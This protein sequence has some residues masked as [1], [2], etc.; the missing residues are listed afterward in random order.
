MCVR[1]RDKENASKE[2]TIVAM[3]MTGGLVV[4]VCEML[5]ETLF[6]YLIYFCSVSCHSDFVCQ[7]THVIVILY[8]K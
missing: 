4:V 2:V 5:T 6:V 3:M 8:V 1:E 7:M